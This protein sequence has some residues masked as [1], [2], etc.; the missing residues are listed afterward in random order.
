MAYISYICHLVQAKTGFIQITFSSDATW[1]PLWP[2]SLL[3]V[4]SQVL[5]FINICTL[6][7]SAVLLCHI[8]LAIISSQ[9][10][11]VFA[12]V[13]CSC[14]VSSHEVFG[15][16]VITE[17]EATPPSVFFKYYP[18]LKALIGLQEITEPFDPFAFLQAPVLGL[19]DL[20]YY[21][22]TS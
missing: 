8:S 19:I 15:C 2:V 14:S 17:I 9:D 12:L 7:E 3:I 16:S 4:H 1:L 18:V 11:Y 20:L 21:A 10:N 22:T 5:C 6:V 13:L